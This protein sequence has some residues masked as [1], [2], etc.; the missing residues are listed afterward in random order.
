MNWPIGVE[1]E[2]LAP[3]GLSRKD[4]A[5]CTAH[6][7]GAEV[8]PFWHPQ[9]EPSKVPGMHIFHNLTPG[10]HICGSD[11]ARIASYVGDL[12]IIDELDKA[13]PASAGWY[14]IL[15]DDLR[16]LSL[17][18]RTADPKT[19]ILSEILQPVAE[20]FDAQVFF[21]DGVVRIEDRNCLPIALGT[22]MPGERE[23]VAEIVTGVIKDSHHQ[24]LEE[25]LEPA[26]NI[27]FQVP[28][29]AATHIHFDA[30]PLHNPRV[31]AN[32]VELLHRYRVPLR[33]LFQT[34]PHCLRLGPWP[35]E[36]LHLT[37]SDDF[38]E[39]TWME[40]TICLKQV[41]LTKYCDF[42]LRNMI[43]ALPDKN[44]FEVRILPGLLDAQPIVEAAEIIERILIKAKCLERIAPQKPLEGKEATALLLQEI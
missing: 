20:L 33:E 40:A 26:R 17:I 14:R 23:R 25:L 16:L 31:F 22:T 4:L 11:G 6:R 44:T 8:V 34:N 15:T 7:L 37:R 36:L 42:N 19:E 18:G 28:L 27:G 13:Q 2:L 12:T 10:F 21:D 24:R 38:N 3:A 1:V 32:L 9:V 30:A 41:G 5:E 43:Y 35:D 29:Q 39:L